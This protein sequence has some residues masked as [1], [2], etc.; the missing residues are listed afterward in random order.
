MEIEEDQ[1]QD[2]WEKR[3]GKAQN[4]YLQ[5]QENTEKIKAYAQAILANPR[6]RYPTVEQTI[7]ASLCDDV[8]FELFT[9]KHQAKIILQIDPG[10]DVDKVFIDRARYF[11]ERSETNRDYWDALSLIVARKFDKTWPADRDLDPYLLGW[12]IDKLRGERLP[13]KKRGGRNSRAYELR[14]GLI[15]DAFDLLTHNGMPAGKAIEFIADE[16]N[17]SQETVRDIVRPRLKR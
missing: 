2:L 8:F 4:D 10:A 3:V 14:N 16:V 11:V 7:A 12:L 17:L 13:P 6:M 1:A 15:C 9:Y 5:D